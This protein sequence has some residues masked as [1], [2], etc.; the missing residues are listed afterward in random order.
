[1][2]LWKG[3]LALTPLNLTRVLSRTR[4]QAFMERPLGTLPWRTLED[5]RPTLGTALGE[6]LAQ[7]GRVGNNR[8]RRGT[9]VEIVMYTEDWLASFETGERQL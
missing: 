1:M 9:E 4:R 7:S 5:N 3:T 6:T 8:R 2:A